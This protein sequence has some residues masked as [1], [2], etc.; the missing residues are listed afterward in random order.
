MSRSIYME[1]GVH[2]ALAIYQTHLLN[3]SWYFGPRE[4]LLLHPRPPDQIQN[5][6]ITQAKPDHAWHALRKKKDD[7]SG[8]QGQPQQSV[9]DA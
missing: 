3:S 7:W 1:L 8:D 9:L 6:D 5:P 4:D 2:I